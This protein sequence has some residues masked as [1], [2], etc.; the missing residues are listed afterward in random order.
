MKNKKILILGGSEL[1]LPAI[2]KS[3]EMGLFVIVADM[4]SSAVGV[5]FADVFEPISTLD[6]EG[7]L[8]LSLRYDIDSIITIA[9][10]M[11]MRTIAKV[12][13]IMGLRNIS[14]DC[15]MK[16]TDKYLM[17][18]ALEKYGVPIP[19]YNKVNTFFEF[20]EICNLHINKKLIIKPADNSGSRGVK[21]VDPLLIDEAESVFNYAKQYSKSGD[22]LIE[23]YLEGPE[24][25]VETMTYNGVTK[26]LAITDKIT[27]GQPYFVE[28]GHVEPSQLNSQMKDEISR[29]AIN[30]ITAIGIDYGP[31]HVEII[32]TC[33]GP[34]IVELGARMGG[35][36]ITTHLVP[37]STGIDMLSNTIEISLGFRPRDYDILNKGAAI[38][39][40]IFKQG[41]IKRIDFSPTSN[42]KKFINKLVLDLKAGDIIHEIRNS[43]D[44]YGYVICTGS[45][46][47]EALDNCQDVVNSIKIEYYK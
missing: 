30:A 13:Q 21:F 35:D 12:S 19:F 17:R 38:R 32:N 36:N 18:L 25:S 28:L 46:G 11:P 29:I 15:A 39:Y 24:V 20:Q 47:K 33:D 7:I 42:Q 40:F 10:D 14:L 1:Q 31:A 44:R 37:L 23:E 2:I 22:V 5:K 41:K 27:S 16:A 45:D 4:N 34:K 26:I 8:D 43:S 9:S 6:T 3:K